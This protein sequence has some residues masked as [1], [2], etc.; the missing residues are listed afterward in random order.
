MPQR[1]LT[2]LCSVLGCYLSRR[3]SLPGYRAQAWNPGHGL[4]LRVSDSV[5]SHPYGP[6]FLR[7]WLRPALLLSGGQRDCSR[8]LLSSHGHD[9]HRRER[10]FAVGGIWHWRRAFPTKLQQ[11]SPHHRGLIW[12]TCSFQT[13]HCW[14]GLDLVLDPAGPPPH[15]PPRH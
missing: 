15:L 12:V 14:G 2:W 10:P 8:S 9:L 6:A 7:V 3:Q 11:L 1:V 13:N 4:E 5:L